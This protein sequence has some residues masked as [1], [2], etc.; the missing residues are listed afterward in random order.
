MVWELCV[1]AAAGAPDLLGN[2]HLPLEFLCLPGDSD[3]SGGGTFSR[4]LGLL[5]RM[6]MMI[7]VRFFEVN[8]EGKVPVIKVDGKWVADSDVITGSMC[9]ACAD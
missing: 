2:C 1:K 4:A 7:I 3:D 9:S 8:P 5:T 6:M